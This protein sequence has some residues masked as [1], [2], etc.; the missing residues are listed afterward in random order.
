[1]PRAKKVD[2]AV[3]RAHP[4]RSITSEGH[5]SSKPRSSFSR[6]SRRTMAGSSA[7]TLRRA[8]AT[9]RPTS[10]ISFSGFFAPAADR[11]ARRD[12]QRDPQSAG[13]PV[14]G[15][16]HVLATRHC[17][18]VDAR[19]DVT[20]DNRASRPRTRNSRRTDATD[21]GLGAWGVGLGPEITTQAPA[22]TQAPSPTSQAHER[23]LPNAEHAADTEPNLD[24]PR[25]RKPQRR[26]NDSQP[27]VW[28]P[29]RHPP[30]AA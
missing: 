18:R 12:P 10:L 19:N 16:A 25:D 22:L 5:S 30:T 8:C 4:N 23:P 20:E 29:Q 15:A 21:L 3:P 2:A 9:P 1:M 13:V 24:G 7:A 26:R 11:A 6:P 17:R 27:A 14:H 28:T